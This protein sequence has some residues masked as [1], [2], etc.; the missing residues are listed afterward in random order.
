MYRSTGVAQMEYDLIIVGGGP[1]GLSAGM[2][3]V[4]SGLKTLVLEKGQAGGQEV[5]SV[6]FCVH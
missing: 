4:R 1:A 6:L 3:G 5:Q 2:Y